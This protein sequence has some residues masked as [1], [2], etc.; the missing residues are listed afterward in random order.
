MKTLYDD[1]LFGKFITG[2]YRNNVYYIGKN[3]ERFNI[4]KS[5]YIYLI[6]VYNKEGICQDEIVNLLKVDKYEV[7]KGVKSLIEKGYLYKEKD[8]VDK[9]KHRLYSTDKAKEIEEYIRNVL[10]NMSEILTEGFNKEEK[11]LALKILKKMDMN[12]REEVKK[13]KPSR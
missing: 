11:E 5:E 6:K 2:I 9:R 4:N 8:E 3:L 12:I 10:R 7:A 13:I 1:Q